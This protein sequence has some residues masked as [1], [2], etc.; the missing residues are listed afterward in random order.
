MDDPDSEA[1][2]EVGTGSDSSSLP[3]SPKN[4][5]ES[6]DISSEKEEKKIYSRRQFLHEKAGFESL[7]SENRYR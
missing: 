7:Q 3:Q 4:F 1:L 6:Q 2:E 5:T